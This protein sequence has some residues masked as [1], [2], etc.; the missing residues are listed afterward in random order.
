MR[1]LGLGSAVLAAGCSNPEAREQAK[2]AEARQAIA[3]AESTVT[4]VATLPATGLWSEAHLMERLVRTGVLP[5]PLEGRVPDAPWMGQ[6]P[7]ALSA[8]GGEVYAWIYAD[9]S[10]RKAVT[11]AL[12]PETGAP[13]GRTSPWAI[14]MQLVINNNLAAIVTGGSERNQDRIALALQ[15]GLPVSP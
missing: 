1:A 10:A 5:R 2:Q 12:D 9:S 13:R 4:K 8:G 15:A 11:D 14:P 6:S 3:A 7:I